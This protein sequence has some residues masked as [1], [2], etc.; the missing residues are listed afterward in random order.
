M[1]P[2][3]ALPGAKLIFYGKVSVY[4]KALGMQP[5]GMWKDWIG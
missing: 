3:I 2:E 1:R 5:E 4:M